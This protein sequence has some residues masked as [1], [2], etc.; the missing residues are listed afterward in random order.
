[1]KDA[2]CCSFCGKPQGEVWDLVLPRK[3]SA[4][5]SICDECVLTCN[6]ILS[7]NAQEKIEPP[8]GQ[9]R[10]GTLENLLQCSFC[11]ISQ[12]KAQHLISSPAGKPT[13]YICDKCVALGDEAMNSVTTKRTFYRGWFA[14]K[15]G[16]FE[17][18]IHRIG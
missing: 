17:T 3:Q 1:M 7:E 13:S 5:V 12:E 18:N 15:T 2:I 4:A 11:G 9:Y 16:K 6:R 14:R 10:L 8:K